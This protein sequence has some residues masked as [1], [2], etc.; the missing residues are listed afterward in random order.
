MKAHSRL[1][2]PLF[3]TTLVLI[4]PQSGAAQVAFAKPDFDI[5]SG[6][7]AVDD[8]NGDGRPDFAVAINGSVTIYLSP[9]DGS[10]GPGTTFSGG[11]NPIVLISTD[12]N[13]DGIADLAELGQDGTITVL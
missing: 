8:F 1:L 10:I 5:Q 11:S 2:L 12:F 3:L 6:A 13:H 9:G 4:I 7:T